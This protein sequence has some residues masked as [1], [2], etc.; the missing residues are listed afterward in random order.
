MSFFKRFNRPLKSLG[1]GGGTRDLPPSS[2]SP[3]TVGIASPLADQLS[4]LSFQLPL[5]TGSFQLFLRGFK[6]A[7][8]FLKIHPLPLDPRTTSPTAAAAVASASASSSTTSSPARL[9]ASSRPASSANADAGVPETRI[10]M[11]PLASLDASLDESNGGIAGQQQQQQQPLL[12]GDS[13][14]PPPTTGYQ[15]I[16]DDATY[17]SFVNQFQRLTILD[18]LMRNTDR[19]LDNWMIKYADGRI[20]VA[21]IDHGLA[22]PFKHPDKWR[23][24]PYGWLYMPLAKLPYQPSLAAYTAQ[25]LR[26]RGA[27]YR[28]LDAPGAA[29]AAGA[30]GEDDDDAVHVAGEYFDATDDDD[31][32][33]ESGAEGGDYYWVEDEDG[34]SARRLRPRLQPSKMYR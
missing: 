22:F 3:N 6:D 24:Y 8:I 25:L 29:R 5:K 31:N 33:S 28:P 32:Y 12:M 17:N 1:A 27:G 2:G 21:A 13:P 18:Y 4:G 10:D 11:T 26:D 7:S 30:Y 9:G 20:Q 23:C 14:A 16:W 34:P 19:G 15:G